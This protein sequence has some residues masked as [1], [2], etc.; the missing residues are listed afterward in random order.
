NRHVISHCGHTVHPTDTSNSDLCPECE[1]TICLKFLDVITQAWIKEGGPWPD[2][3]IREGKWRY[4]ELRKAWIMTRLELQN[5]LD[6][7]ERMA[8][9]ERQWERDH[10]REAERARGQKTGARAL[11]IG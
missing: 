7:F 5:A 8:E 3:G 11:K 10:P 2:Q 9:K 4:D 1:V 6:A